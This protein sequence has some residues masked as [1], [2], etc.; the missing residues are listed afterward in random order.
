MDANNRTP[1]TAD[2]NDTRRQG[3]ASGADAGVSR[4]KL[5]LSGTALAAAAG[6]TMPFAAAEAQTAPTPAPGA[7]P[8]IVVIMGDDV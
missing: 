2:I 7:K 1:E 4:R 5:L 8:N 3:S 6:V